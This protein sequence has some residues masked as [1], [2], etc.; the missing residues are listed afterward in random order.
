MTHPVRAHRGPTKPPPDSDPAARAGRSSTSAHRHR[1]AAVAAV[2]L[3]LTLTGCAQ[4]KEPVDPRQQLMNRPS[5][6]QAE[7]TYLALLDR[8]RTEITTLAPTLTWRQPEPTAE[9]SGCY[10]PFDRLDGAESG[11]YGAGVA[12]GNID[13]T[14]WP[15]VV[16]AIE[17]IL[18][19][20]GFTQT[21]VLQD[22]P[23]EHNV[24][25]NNPTTEAR[26]RLGTRANTT[27]TLYGACY[28]TEAARAVSSATSS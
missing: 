22:Q 5:Y 28:L 26:V 1:T 12:D 6:E 14:T 16:A 15:K 3:T 4:P 19:E 21:V 2:V 27:L 20:E 8:L 25:I 11:I 24:S 13:D 7:T 23:G 18:R 10:P 9:R 17:A